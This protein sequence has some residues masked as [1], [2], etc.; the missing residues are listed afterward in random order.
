MRDARAVESRGAFACGYSSGTARSATRI[1]GELRIPT[2]GI[3]AGPDC[4]GQILVVNDLLGLT[5][6]QNAEVR[7]PIRQRRRSD[8]ERR[9]RLL[10]D[11]RGGTFPSDAESYHSGQ[12]AKSKKPVYIDC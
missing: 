4:D 3:G 12:P 2:I 6:G 8:L 1:T 9:S 11:V 7:P 5:F 10:R